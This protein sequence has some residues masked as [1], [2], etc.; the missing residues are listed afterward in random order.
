MV[1]A[2]ESRIGLTFGQILSLII[3]SGG[4]ITAYVDLNIKIADVSGKYQSSE[5]RFDQLEKG[6][7]QNAI[8]IETI[9]TENREDHKMLNDKIDK[10]LEVLK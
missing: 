8:N 7:V 6:R 10:I 1:L 9:R 3:L 2:K 5:I 4:I